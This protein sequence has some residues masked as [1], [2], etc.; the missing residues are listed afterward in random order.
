MIPKYVT[1][2]QPIPTKEIK[3][4]TIIMHTIGLRVA[5]LK[6]DTNQ[7]Y[8]VVSGLLHRSR[9][10]HL[11][12]PVKQPWRIWINV[13]RESNQGGYKTMCLLIVCQISAFGP[14]GKDYLHYA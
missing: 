13:S 5:L 1:T 11:M 6:L 2:E 10:N 12:V 4:P 7:L 3:T 9:D 14:A 8:L